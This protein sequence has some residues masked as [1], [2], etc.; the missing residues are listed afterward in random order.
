MFHVNN[1]MQSQYN[2]SKLMSAQMTLR[3]SWNWS[4]RA[5][6]HTRWVLYLAFGHHVLILVHLNFSMSWYLSNS[7]GET[8]LVSITSWIYSD[9]FYLQFY[10]PKSLTWLQ[11]TIAALHSIHTYT[12]QAMALNS[13]Q[14]SLLKISPLFSNLMNKSL[15]IPLTSVALERLF[16]RLT[17][18][19]PF[20]R[21]VW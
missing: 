12:P 9:E 20:F 6:L 1:C 7:N 14:I 13:T 4:N 10:S 3:L 5:V 21:C 11:V 8:W 19:G 18:H 15:R 16:C 2:L 17:H